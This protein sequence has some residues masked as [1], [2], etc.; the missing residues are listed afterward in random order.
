MAI[1]VTAG[2]TGIGLEICS[3]L[4]VQNFEIIQT[5]SR[6]ELVDKTSNRYYL[7]LA[8]PES[9]KELS[10]DLKKNNIS[11]THI[12]HCAHK[13]SDSKLF[14]NIT[15]NDL[16]ESLETNVIGTFEFLRIF[17]KTMTRKSFGRILIIGSN[18]AKK[19]APGK[20]IYITEKNA[21]ESMALAINTEVIDRNVKIKILH[22]SLVATEQVLSRI[23]PQVV[24]HIGR[25]N[26][27]TP[28][29]V[30]KEAIGFLMNESELES[31]KIY[32]GNQQ[33]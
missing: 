18:L 2:L 32:N 3:Q 13:F 21:I 30:A 27:L 25:E 28:T 4:K 26:L 7:N 6:V 1:L 14:L 15:A 23:T 22:P 16:R 31:I 20:L 12:F 8:E 11:I 29:S 24:N 5:T 10:I 9:I 33:W 19:P 17:S